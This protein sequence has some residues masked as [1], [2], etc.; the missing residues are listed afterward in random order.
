[1]MQTNPTDR[2]RRVQA[3]ADDFNSADPAMKNAVTDGLARDLASTPVVAAGTM[4][5]AFIACVCMLGMLAVYAYRMT[6]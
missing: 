4:W 3:A 1:M 5:P 6:F 2:A